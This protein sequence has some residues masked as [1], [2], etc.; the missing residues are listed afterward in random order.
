M[1]NFSSGGLGAAVTAQSLDSLHTRQQCPAGAQ[2]H[3]HGSPG[4][5]NPGQGS[6]LNLEPWSWEKGAS[7]NA[8]GV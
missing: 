7:P 8:L 5:A 1:M 6:D 3:S 4:A 2:A